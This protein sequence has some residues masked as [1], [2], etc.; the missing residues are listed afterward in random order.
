MTKQA[1]VQ[2]LGERR[3]SERLSIE[4]ATSVVGR[5]FWFWLCSR[6]GR[7]SEARACVRACLLCCLAAR[8]PVGVFCLRHK[9]CQARIHALAPSVAASRGGSY[10]NRAYLAASSHQPHLR[11]RTL[12][13]TLHRVTACSTPSLFSAFKTKASASPPPPPHIRSC[14]PRQLPPP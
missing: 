5:T 13:K 9:Q 11:P 10:C 12:S 4:G 8:L 6:A 2:D 1:C 7:A 14:Q 3:V